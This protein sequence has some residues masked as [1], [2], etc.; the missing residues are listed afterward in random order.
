M[1]DYLVFIWFYVGFMFVCL[2]VFCCFILFFVGFYMVFVFLCWF[3]KV[4]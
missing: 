4:L 3:F 1:V 2:L